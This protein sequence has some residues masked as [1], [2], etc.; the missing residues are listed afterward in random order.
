[1]EIHTLYVGQGSLSVITG[2]NEAIIVDSCIPPLTDPYAEFMKAAFAKILAG[3]EVVGLM[4]TGLDADHADPPGVAWILRKYQPTWVMYPQYKKLTGTAGR[5]FK[6]IKQAREEREG[7]ARPLVRYP[8]RI[9]RIENRVLSGIS[10]EWNMIV[11]SP[12]PED[13]GSSNNSS[14]VAKVVPKNR[15]FGF[16]YLITGDTEN[17]R[18]ESINRIFGRELRAEVMAAPHHGSRNGINKETLQLVEPEIVLVNAG[19]KNQ[20][21]HPHQEAMD[22][23]HGVAAKVYS[24]HDGKSFCTSGHWWWGGTREWT[25]N[26]TTAA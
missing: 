20:F 15:V 24:T 7:T 10:R 4:L 23:Y 11:F 1:M 5:V 8:I 16:R 21:G 6:I 3:K 17:P 25:V 13:M 19:V 14:L 26:E 18:W 22:L 2:E 9:D 12:H